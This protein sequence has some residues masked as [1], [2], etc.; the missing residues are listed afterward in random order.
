MAI[1]SF[2][3]LCSLIFESDSLASW[4]QSGEMSSMAKPGYLQ[5]H[6]CVNEMTWWSWPLTWTGVEERERKSFISHYKD[7]LF[8]GGL[9]CSNCY[10]WSTVYYRILNLKPLENI[11]MLLLGCN[12]GHLQLW[13]SLLYFGFITFSSK[14]I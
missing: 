2:M 8:Y 5:R 9:C 1:T 11:S 14:I 3:T 13:G 6:F 7:F 4:L 12:E 10:L